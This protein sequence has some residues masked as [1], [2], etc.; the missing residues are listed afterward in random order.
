MVK[1]TRGEDRRGLEQRDGLDNVT[2]MI[3]EGSRIW[4]VN[5]YLLVSLGSFEISYWTFMMK[6]SLMSHTLA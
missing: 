2:M 4:V 5:R 6:K 3:L 1:E